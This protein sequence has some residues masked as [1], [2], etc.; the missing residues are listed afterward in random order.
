MPSREQKA[1]AALV[2]ELDDV[3]D[4]L[5]ALTSNGLG[6]GH[7]RQEVEQA[8]AGIDEAGR[9][10]DEDVATGVGLSVEETARYLDL[11]AQ[12]V[13]SWIGRGVLAT[14]P[15]AKPRQI[16]RESAR[17]TRRALGQLRERGQDRDW[18]NA[19]ADHLQDLMDLQSP[20]V[21]HGLED[22]ERGRLEP[23]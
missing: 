14:V 7:V 19:V 2:V 8:I 23:A 3:R 6:R 12:T 9:R 22:I 18:L 20:G 13:R 1:A 15:D 10:L 17:R 5:A 4:R 16:D 11:S 21:R